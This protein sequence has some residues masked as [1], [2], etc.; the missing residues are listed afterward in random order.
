M[1]SQQDKVS[2]KAALRRLTDLTN[3]TNTP[4]GGVYLV[5]PVAQK[6]NF[7]AMSRPLIYDL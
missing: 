6:Q 4:H 5:R 2:E 7:N 1:F 3:E